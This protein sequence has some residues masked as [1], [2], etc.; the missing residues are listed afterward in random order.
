VQPIGALEQDPDVPGHFSWR[1][2]PRALV[3][4]CLHE[5][6]SSARTPG[7]EKGC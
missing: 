3:L 2:C 5:P 1:C 7:P 6:T 4:S